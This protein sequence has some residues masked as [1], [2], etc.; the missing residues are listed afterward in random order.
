MAEIGDTLLR[1][2]QGIVAQLQGQT[3]LRMQ[4]QQF[5]AQLQQAE[6]T[7]SLRQQ[8]IEARERKLELDEQ[9]FLRK[10]KEAPIRQRFLEAQAAAMEATATPER[11]EQQRRLTESIIQKN[12]TAGTVRPGGLT[13]YQKFSAR[14][15]FVSQASEMREREL[16]EGF[17]AAYKVK[18]RTPEIQQ[19]ER[20]TAQS[21]SGLSL[22]ELIDRRDSLV[23]GAGEITDPRRDLHTE[24]G[25]VNEVITQVRAGSSEPM[26]E[27][28]LLG[29]VLKDQQISPTDPVGV[30]SVADIMNAKPFP[31]ERL[32]LIFGQQAVNSAAS[33]SELTTRL[34]SDDVDWFVEQL[35]SRAVTP[36]GSINVPVLDNF[37]QW[38]EFSKTNPDPFLEKFRDKMFGQ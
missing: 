14:Q 24:L 18:G 1:A 13:A 29:R 19:Q 9:D 3:R 8:E 30:M 31:P 20:T 2:A 23:P 15:K 26:S 38:V 16:S 36:D 21:L 7:F 17:A 11:Q 27:D 37:F 4:Q 5:S 33:R 10:Q 25:I 32:G 12:L 22:Q 34:E 28:E 6:R 35:R